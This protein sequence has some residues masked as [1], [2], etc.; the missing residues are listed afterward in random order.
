MKRKKTES[1]KKTKERQ[2]EKGEEQKRKD[3]KEKKQKKRKGEKSTL[4]SGQD[5]HGRKHNSATT[6]TAPG[7]LM[8]PLLCQNSSM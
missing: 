3:K 1:G 8:M 6:V 5:Q 2:I 7:L 4:T